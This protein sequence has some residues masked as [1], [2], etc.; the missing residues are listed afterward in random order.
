MSWPDLSH[1]LQLQFLFDPHRTSGKEL[2]RLSECLSTASGLTWKVRSLP[3]GAERTG[4]EQG[5]T[6]GVF[7]QIHDIFSGLYRVI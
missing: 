7:S 2:V 1:E 4:L 3:E 5:R 6:K